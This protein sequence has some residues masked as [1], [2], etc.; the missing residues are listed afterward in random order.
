MVSDGDLGWALSVVLR[1]YL[2]AATAATAD[3]PGGPRCYQVLVA[4]A[5]EEPGSQTVLAQRLGIDRTIL[6]YLIDD[7][8][9]AGLVERQPDPAD[10][11]NRRVVTTTH[12]R[13][14]LADLDRRVRRAE[15]HLLAG[16]AAG[17]QANL[18]GL[19]QRV[20]SYANDLDP[21]ADACDAVADIAGHEAGPGQRPENLVEDGRPGAVTLVSTG[22]DPAI[23]GEPPE[24][25]TRGSE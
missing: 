18:R 17:E 11:R 7:L 9:A 6:T 21:V 2:K 8:V 23:T 14:V 3:L 16:L 1:A 20:A 5:R 13:R 15:D 22:D 4:V 10:R 19:L 24:E 25:R 12:G